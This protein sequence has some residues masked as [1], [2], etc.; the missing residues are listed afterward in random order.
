MATKPI[1]LVVDDEEDILDVVSYNLER[2]GYTVW[3]AGSGEAALDILEAKQLPDLFLLDVML[4]GIGGIDLCKRLKEQ[5]R[6]RNIPVVFLSARNEEPDIVVGLELGADDYITKPFRIR[7]LQA[8]IKAH[9]RRGKNE[10]VSEELLTVGA[11]VISPTRRQVTLNGKLVEL[12]FT[13]FEILY[14]LARKPGRVFT[15]NQIVDA[16]RGKDYA[17]TDRSVDVQVVGLRKKLGSIDYIE[18]VRGVGYRF[19]TLE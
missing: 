5:E 11:L 17:V 12:K 1:I 10:V 4:P 16:I 9:L 7:E 19:R 14:I 13:E 3:K 18:T 15:R 2:D 6:T 8:R